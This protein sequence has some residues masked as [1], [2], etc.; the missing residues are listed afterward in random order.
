MQHSRTKIVATL[1]PASTDPAVFCRLLE[2]GLDV[3][4]LNFS[5][6][7]L[8]TRRTYLQVARGIADQQTL[9]I[10]GDLC[11]PKIR[12]G[13]VGGPGM[14]VE[15][16][17]EITF[18]REPTLGENKTLSSNY[19]C[20]VDDL[21]VGQRVLIDDGLI[22]MIVMDKTPDSVRCQVTV[23]GCIL[24][25][26]GL[27]L[28]NTRVNLPSVTDKDWQDIDWAIEQRLD[29]LALSFVRSAEDVRTVRKYLEKRDAPIGLV[30]KIEMPQAI[31]DLDAIIE[32]SD[33]VLVA[34]GDLGVEMDLTAVPLLQKKIVAAC[35]EAG[36]PV[37]VATQM[38]QS[39]V[40]NASPTRA[41][42]SDVANAILDGA[43]AV[44]LS[45]ETAVGK[46]PV[47]AVLVLQEIAA[48]TESYIIK[49]GLGFAAPKLL[50]MTHNRTA[51]IAHGAYNIAADVD[52]RLVVV[53]SQAG[54]SAR[55]MSKNRF[56]IPIIALSTDFAAVRRMAMFFGVRPVRADLP[57]HFDDLPAMVDELLTRYGWA[58][59]GDRVV[60]A[61][62]APLGTAGVTNSL[63]VHTVGAFDG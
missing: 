4:R 52:A 62:G 18:V 23:G 2:A 5:H 8:Q 38:L 1:G 63:S 27:N 12:V 32:A 41:E 9:A 24:S 37:I 35:H 13:K 49:Q 55:Y 39:M 28:P 31:D 50:Q 25:N 53:W 58:Q 26:K 47:G 22:R 60:I 17:D 57:K 3:A 29:Y 44:M 46:Y 54:G 34:R 16:G 51:A 48:Q 19:A 43:D 42:V 15:P 7:D 10:M 33:V 30:S 21:E 40:D 6:G 36:V 56:N 45:G 11:G 14:S 61:A 59:N 20:L